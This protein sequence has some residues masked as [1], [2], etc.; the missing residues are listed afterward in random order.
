MSSKGKQPE[1]KELLNEQDAERGDAV[2][3]RRSMTTPLTAALPHRPGSIRYND[4]LLLTLEQP[5]TIHE[6]E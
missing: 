4:G 3:P 1:V 2:G 5:R 6:P